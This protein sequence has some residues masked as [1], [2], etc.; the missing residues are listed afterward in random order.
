VKTGTLALV[1]GSQKSPITVD[2]GAT[3]G[4]TLGS[5]TTSTSTVAFSGATA[6]VKVTGTPVAATLMTATAITGTPVLD[7]AIAGFE[8]AIEDGGTTL[9]L[10][11]A[12][13]ANYNTWANDY[14][15]GQSADLDHDNDGVSNGV[16]YFMGQTGS[17]FTANPGVIA[18]KVTWPKDPA[19]VG[20]FKV[21]V[22][23]TLALGSWTDIVPPDASIDETNP[24]QVVFTMP[25][26]ASKKFAR[27][28]VVVP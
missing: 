1:G 23:D 15:S 4:F 11:V 10:K 5:S 2:S 21:Q 19:F 9:K 14:A 28:N 25:T 27:L 17:T 13:T 16:E 18:G 24:N 22:S 3:L 8:L 26:G 7:P 6:K 20:S 12:S